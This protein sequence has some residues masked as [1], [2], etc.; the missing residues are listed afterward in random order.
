MDQERLR[1][2]E[3]IMRAQNGRPF[4]A[5]RE[6]LLEIDP[7]LLEHVHEYLMAAERGDEITEKLRHLIYLAADCVVTHLYPG[8]AAVH[9]GE[10]LRN[11]AS[12]RELVETLG[13][14]AAVSCRGYGIGLPVVVAA[15]DRHFGRTGRQ[16]EPFTASELAAKRRVESRLGYWA[17]WM[18]DA[19]RLSP[20]YLERLAE[21]GR[22]DPEDSALDPKSRELIF[23]G[24]YACPAM[25]DKDGMRAHA[26]RALSL[27]ATESELLQTL[28]I[29]NGIGLHAI[30]E[31]IRAIKEPLAQFL[32]SA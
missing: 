13:I 5:W 23:L 11:G 24:A 28:R 27:G 8:G 16:R 32:P 14:A 17:D 30:S 22:P 1:L 12:R 9:A 19:L 26:E 7:P 2:K 31:G 20:D 15:V 18:D 25:V 3:K 6:T 29:A 10:A 4:A 21:F